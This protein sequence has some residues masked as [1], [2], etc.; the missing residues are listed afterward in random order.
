ME[1][2]KNADRL[3]LIDTVSIACEL[4]KCHFGVVLFTCT[5]NIAYVACNLKVQR[6]TDLV[7]G[8]WGKISD[9]DLFLWLGGGL[10][11]YHNGK[12]SIR[13]NFCV[14]DAFCCCKK[15]VCHLF[16][17]LWIYHQWR[18]VDSTTALFKLI[19]TSDSVYNLLAEHFSAIF[20][21]EC[22]YYRFLLLL[23]LLV[24]VLSFSPYSTLVNLYSTH[25]PRLDNKNCCT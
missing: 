10:G 13:T 24:L 11:L 5:I 3:R 6:Y 12:Y 2:K 7:W 25:F 9:T 15:T 17:F 18:G 14:C 8:R 21:L 22:Y 20:V 16:I 23:L 19:S 1:R 4:C